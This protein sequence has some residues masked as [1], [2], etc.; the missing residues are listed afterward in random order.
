MPRIVILC[1]PWG[2]TIFACF[3]YFQTKMQQP[4]SSEKTTNFSTNE[5][6]QQSTLA[7]FKRPWFRRI[8]VLQEVAAARNVLI[9]CGP[10]GI[11]G[12]AFC[13]GVE[14]L[15][16]FN[17]IPADLQSLICSTTYLIRGAIF[18]SKHV[19]NRL[20]RVSQEICPLGGLVDMYHTRIATKRHDK[21]YY[22]LGMSS[23]DLRKANLAPDYRVPWEE[24]LQ[25]LAKFL[26]GE[27]ISVET[28]SDKEIAII[29]SKGCILGEV[30]SVYK[31]ALDDS[32]GVDVIFKNIP[33]QPEDM[34]MHW[35]LRPSAKSIRE[36][37]FIC[38]FEG[39]SEPA[40]I[41]LCGDYFTL[42]MTAATPLEDTRLEE[43]YIEWSNHFQLVKQF[44]RDFL[45]VWDWKDSSENLQE[46]EI[47]EIL[48]R[49]N[50]RV[51]EL[52]KTDR[53]GLLDKATRAWNVASIL[54]DLRKYKKAEERLREA[55]EGY[56]VAFKRTGT[57]V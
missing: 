56:K 51:S 33:G 27:K 8:W 4:L 42:I 37:D 49:T 21:V 17:K 20:G 23:D 26:L 12:Y 11:D 1:F 30:S 2:A 10:T 38:L 3:G 34:K 29:K 15:K 6:I 18:R 36:G 13:L 9:L 53:E 5:G 43:G 16:E 52:S 54:G 40:I 35:T 55:I 48:I 57:I 14:S 45:L 32:Q 22:L 47:Y 46:S 39:A 44:V 41:R 7:L 24:L 28:W 25:R 31:D 19:M 50:N